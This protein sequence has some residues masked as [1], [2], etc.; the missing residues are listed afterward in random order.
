MAWW[1]DNNHRLIQNNIRDI[2]I[3]MDIDKQIEWLK[4]F[5][6]NVFMINC[7]GITAFYPT[8]LEYQYRNPYMKENQDFIREVVEKCH[9]NGIKVT[10]RF[11]FSKTDESFYEKHPEWYTRTGTGE[12]IHFNGIIA[13]CINSE[14]QQKYSLQI[15][16]E[17]L[18]NYDVDGIF[19]NMF[20]YYTKDAYTGKPIGLCQCENCKQRFF[21]YF[22][23]TLP[24]EEDL[25]NPVYRHYLEFKAKTVSELLDRIHDLTKAINPNVAI[26]T[27]H[28]NKVDMIRNESNSAI[29]RAYPFWLYSSSQNV[30]VVEGSFDDKVSSNCVINAVDIFPR[31]MGVSKYLTQIRLYENIASGSGLDYCIIG[32]FEGYPDRDNFALAQEVFKFHSQYERYFGHFTTLAKIILVKP[33]DMMLALKQCDLREYLGIFKML[34]EEHRLFRVVSLEQ[35]ADLIDQIDSSYIVILPGL[36]QLGSVRLCDALDKSDAVVI[37]TGNALTEAPDERLRLFGVLEDQKADAVRGSYLLTEPKAVFTSFADRDWVYL[38]GD[39]RILSCAGDNESLLNLISV[40]RFGPPE[41]CYGHEQTQIPGVTLHRQNKHRNRR[42]YFPWQPGLLYYKD[43]FED[44]KFLLLDLLAY[45]QPAEQLLT[46]NAPASVEIFFDQCGPKQYLLQLLNLSGFNGTTVRAPLPIRDLT[47]HVNLPIPRNITQLC[48]EGP[49]AKPA[50]SVIDI[51][52]LDPYQA[53]L[54]EI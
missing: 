7:G 40:A 35:L 39:F 8:Q 32:G 2:D 9:A 23:E 1:L 33:S 20:G 30:A 5:D 52:L 48:A 26:S 24:V 44:F 41:R 37:A 38:D 13:T 11:D 18:E 54:L 21:D 3:R 17:V 50:T 46:T 4:K 22:G 10:A 45:L 16:R 31:F 34:K 36:A 12:L 19:F 28:H 47:V 29:D 43:G 15:I 6:C 42:A 14:Y 27:Y 51:D 53:Y 25:E 49:I